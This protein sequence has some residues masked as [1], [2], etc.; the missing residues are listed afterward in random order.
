MERAKRI[1]LSSQPW[2][3]RV[4]PL[5]HARKIGSTAYK[6]IITNSNRFVH[7]YFLV[8]RDVLPVCVCFLP[9]GREDVV[10]AP[11]SRTE[12]ICF[13]YGF[14]FTAFCTFGLRCACAKYGLARITATASSG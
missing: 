13:K 9:E 14:S 10:D 1:E 3:G 4:L 12:A 8:R 2:Q 7:F 11:R 5:N 6:E